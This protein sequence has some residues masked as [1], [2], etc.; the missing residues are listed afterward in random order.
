MCAV[1]IHV[2]WDVLSGLLF[3]RSVWCRWISSSC[4]EFGGVS[5]DLLACLESS[6]GAVSIHVVW[7]VFSEL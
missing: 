6:V 4:T 3:Q 7:D 1:S 2:V 5:F